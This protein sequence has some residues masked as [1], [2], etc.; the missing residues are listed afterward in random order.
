MAT[1]L[2]RAY[3]ESQASIFALAN[4]SWGKAADLVFGQIAGL[5]DGLVAACIWLAVGAWR[6]RLVVPAL[7]AFVISGLFVQVLKHLWDVPRPAAVLGHVHV[8]G[9]PLFAHAFPS[10]HAA[11]SGALAAWGWFA[12]PRRIGVP[13]AFLGL[14]AAYARVYGGAH[15]PLDVLVGFVAGLGAYLLVRRLRVREDK[16]PKLAQAFAWLAVV[17]GAYLALGHHVQPATARPLAVLVGLA[18]IGSAWLR[19]RG[20]M[21]W[22]ARA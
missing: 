5:G 20:G 18:A 17:A 8:L 19:L 10:G 9:A 1:E 12:L 4:A 15:W 7:A 11:T 21:P 22:R 3:W 6:P 2:A 16:D 13:V 14:L